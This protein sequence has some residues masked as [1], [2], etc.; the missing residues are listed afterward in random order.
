MTH[1]APR[2]PRPRPEAGTGGPQSR[3]RQLRRAIAFVCLPGVVLGLA[4]AVGAFTAGAFDHRPADDVALVTVPM[5]GSFAVRVL[6]GS[7]RNGLARNAASALRDE[8]FHIT[9]VGNAPE[10]TWHD[11]AAV[12]WHGQDGRDQARLVADQI[13]GSLLME[14]QRLGTGVEVILGTAYLGV[15]TSPRQLP[16]TR[17]E[18]P[19]VSRPLHVDPAGG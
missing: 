6:N 3:H 12:I 15:I 1:T 11:H 19:A 8:G 7:G 16:A 9:V 10:R 13:P 14:D 17:E 2:P 4:L 5:R 18:G